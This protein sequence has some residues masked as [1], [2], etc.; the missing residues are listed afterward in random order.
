MKITKLTKEMIKSSVDWCLEN[1][2][3]VSFIEMGTLEDGRKLCLVFGWENGYDKG[4]DF[5]YHDDEGLWTLCSKLAVNTDDLQ[6]DYEMDWTMPYHEDGEV[7]ATDMAVR[8]DEDGE[9]YMKEA[10]YMIDALNS[11]EVKA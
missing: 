9:Y 1:H 11:G 2:D 4:E 7:W 8:K 6:C 3:G 5:Q 10:K